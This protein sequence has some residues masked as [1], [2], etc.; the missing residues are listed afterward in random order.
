M[1][2]E[3]RQRK[4]EDS[5]KRKNVGIAEAYA[6]HAGLSSFF[7]QVSFYQTSSFL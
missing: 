6:R 5:L 2:E 1:R 3:R 7:D 4:E